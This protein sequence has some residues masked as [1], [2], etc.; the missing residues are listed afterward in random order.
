MFF[1][2]LSFELKNFPHPGSLRA[3][4][5]SWTPA[6]KAGLQDK[7]DMENVHVDYVRF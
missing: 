1:L 2:L 6:A 3:F 4:T 7:F 5:N